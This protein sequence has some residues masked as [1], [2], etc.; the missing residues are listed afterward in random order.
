MLCKKDVL[1]KKEVWVC[2]CKKEVWVCSVRGEVW[3]V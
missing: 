3:I 1:C 2:C